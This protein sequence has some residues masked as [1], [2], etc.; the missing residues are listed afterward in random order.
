MK[1]VAVGCIVLAV[2]VLV[3]S[4]WAA[5]YQVPE[6][7]PRIFIFA[8]DIPKIAQR[9][10]PGGHNASDYA[11]LKNYVDHE[12]QVLNHSAMSF[13]FVCLVEKHL[14]HPTERYVGL[15]KKHILDMA[16]KNM[17]QENN[18][19]HWQSLIAADWVFDT[20][21]DAEKQQLAQG[22]RIQEAGAWPYR[23]YHENVPCWRPGAPGR[24]L[25]RLIRSL[26]FYGEGIAD[27]KAKAELDRCCEYIT[28]ELGPALNLSGGPDPSGFG[29]AT[30]TEIWSGW[31]FP[32][33][34]RLGVDC[35]RD[36]IWAQQYPE[37]Y[38][39]CKI[40][41]EEALIRRDD[42][43]SKPLSGPS[44]LSVPMFLQAGS[45]AG[46]WWVDHLRGGGRE[47]FYPAYLWTKIIWDD[48][49]VAPVKIE[50]FPP[51]KYFA[52]G[53]GPGKGMGLVVWRS[54]W[55][56]EATLFDFR[57]GDYFYGHQ[58]RDTGSFILHKGG[59]LAIDPGPYFTYA[60]E[61][62][63]AFD[64]NYHHAPV[65]HNLV[66]LF[67][68][69]DGAPIDQRIPSPS[70][71]AYYMYK[72]RAG[73]FN[74][75]DILAYEDTKYY[76]YVLADITP[77]YDE[78][79]LKKQLRAIVYLKP[80]TFIIYDRTIT[81]PGIAKRWLLHA[82]FPP[83]IARFEN[84]LSVADTGVVEHP[85]A[86]IFVVSGLFTGEEGSPLNGRV[87]LPKEPL[88]RTI[89][90]E[91]YRYWVDGKNYHYGEVNEE[92]KQAL[93]RNVPMIGWGRIEIE[94]ESDDSTFLVVLSARP[95]DEPFYPLVPA[96]LL[97]RDELLGVKVAAQNWLCEVLFS[98]GVPITGHITITDPAKKTVV[99]TDLATEVH[100]ESY[101]P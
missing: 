84:R 87:F 85:G 61:N 2:L 51:C 72:E 33:W 71:S 13:A 50:E 69:E 25:A 92:A 14:G 76:A 7:H 44:P 63:E 19:H 54:G 40:P 15:L 75:G 1:A 53:E 42:S 95:M 29:Y 99:D 78:P 86:P 56:E 93:E 88:V 17:I 45:K 3:P 100:P 16:R 57:C 9:C 18:W 55:D 74:L 8:E 47:R 26:C 90:G 73:D 49:S 46:R 5:E 70:D 62:G 67:R 43:T 21:T 91:G 60:A 6:S 20:F 64:N 77:A 37:W 22:M 98:R 12:G 65:A 36:N 97:E 79:A 66:A 96:Q 80:N 68:A 83:F 38:L 28:R 4:A 27:D 101:Q 39:Y 94:D 41:F 24:V 89:G 52:S 11:D 10:Q 34:Q 81:D 82:K 58:H 30:F 48:G 59:H 35:W 31:H 32:I 23:Y